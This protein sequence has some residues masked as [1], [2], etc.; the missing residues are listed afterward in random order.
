MKTIDTV[1]KQDAGRLTQALVRSELL[2]QRGVAAVS[3][4][5]SRNLISIEYDPTVVDDS[6]LMQIIR[7]YGAWSESGSTDRNRYGR[8]CN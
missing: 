3:F 5:P 4:E 8:S 2:C 6:T 1:L 7:L